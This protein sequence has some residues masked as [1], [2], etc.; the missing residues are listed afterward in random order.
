MKELLLAILIVLSLSRFSYGEVNPSSDFDCG[1]REPPADGVY[2][3]NDLTIKFIAPKGWK[4]A[5]DIALGQVG[6]INFKPSCLAKEGLGITFFN[7]P[8]LTQDSQAVLNEALK[9]AGDGEDILKKEVIKV[10]DTDAVSLIYAEEDIMMRN[11]SFFKNGKRFTIIFFASKDNFGRLLP[12]IDKSLGTFEIVSF[13]P[14][15]PKGTLKQG[16]R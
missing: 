4:K 2:K 7:A 1:L 9:T 12:A 8:Y 3:I 11:V 15:R 13:L 14:K 10:D 5:K 16:I 6:V